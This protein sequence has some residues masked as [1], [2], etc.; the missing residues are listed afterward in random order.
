MQRWSRL[1]RALR[2][3]SL[4]TASG[5]GWATRRTATRSAPQ[6][7]PLIEALAR[8]QELGELPRLTALR[9]PDRDPMT[10][11]T[12]EESPFEVDLLQHFE[13]EIA[14]VSNDKVTGLK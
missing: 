7:N 11:S 1:A 2:R 8:A 10:E 9:I 5:T 6:Q 13:N 4:A 14:Q 12:Q 3:R